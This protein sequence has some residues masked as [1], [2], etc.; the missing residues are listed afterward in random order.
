MQPSSAPV[1]VFFQSYKEAYYNTGDNIGE[2]RS[3]YKRLIENRIDL[4]RQF[5][6]FGHRLGPTS[7]V[8]RYTYIRHSAFKLVHIIL[9]F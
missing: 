4:Y 8:F 1:F 7:L 9:Y 2:M 3:G 6:G 5:S